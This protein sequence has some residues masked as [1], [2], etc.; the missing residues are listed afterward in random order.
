MKILHVITSLE[1]GGAEK[2]LVDIVNLQR[3]K[4][5]DVDV[6]VLYD[7]ENVFSINSITS[8]YNSK[9][10]YKNIFEILSVIKKGDY[11]IVHT[12][13]THAQFWTSLASF[14]DCTQICKCG[15][16]KRRYITSE[17][18]TYNNRREKAVFKIIEKI[19]YKRYEKV[20]CIT[21]AV[22]DTLVKW[23][24]DK[25]LDRYP[26]IDNGVN[27][28]V[29]SHA[30]PIPRESLGVTSEDRVITMVAR[31]NK[32]KDHETLLN[33]M[34]LLPKK[35]KLLLVGE[36]DKRE[37][38]EKLSAELRLGDRVKFLGVRIDIPNILKTSDIAVQS[39][40]YEGFGIAAVEAMA[41]GIPL[42]GSDVEGLRDTIKG[43]GTLFN[44]GDSKELAKKILAIDALDDKSSI[45]EKQKVKAEEYSLEKSVDKYLKLYKEVVSG[46]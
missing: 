16:K 31:L 27:L 44:K 7:K 35:Y 45:I 17:H 5:E 32:A 25:N 24:D 39:S 28:N 21:K 12:H 36:G 15:K 23:L 9:T 3:E 46:G 19:L 6:L 43:A 13:L 30:T 8:K 38:L 18:S 22:Q 42:L 10:S 20:L 26:I 40:H 1:L 2:L 33:A 4:G 29:F 34:T 37:V 11:D 14:L 41:A